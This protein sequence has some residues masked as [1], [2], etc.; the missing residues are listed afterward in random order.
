MNKTDIEFLLSQN[1]QIDTNNFFLNMIVAIILSFFI[2]ITYNKT[3]Q[4]LSRKYFVHKKG[5]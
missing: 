2:Q 5:L 4:T 3:A 1:I